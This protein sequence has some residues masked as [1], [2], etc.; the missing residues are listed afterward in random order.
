MSARLADRRPLTR[1]RAIRPTSSR[2]SWWHGTSIVALAL[3]SGCGYLSMKGTRR[4]ES[5]ADW[6][7]CWLEAH[8]LEDWPE[9]ERRDI[10]SDPGPKIQEDRSGHAVLVIHDV[11][12]KSAFRTEHVSGE[13]VV[14]LGLPLKKDEPQRIEVGRSE[15]SE[16]SLGWG[17]RSKVRGIVTPIEIER[18]SVTL[19]LELE[20]VRPSDSFPRLV[21]TVKAR[22][23]AAL[24][25]CYFD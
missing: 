24:R 13:L 5:L 12:A 17:R 2:P 9:A 16:G 25:A 11:W 21:D 20:A 3:L 10:G 15:Y 1:A 4:P 23:R 6:R 8:A 19:R 7:T 18:D 14:E 22:R